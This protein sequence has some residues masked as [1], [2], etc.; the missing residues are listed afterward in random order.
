MPGFFSDLLRVLQG[1]HGRDMRFMCHQLL[2]ERGEASQTVLAQEI[3][4]TYKSMNSVQRHDF[5]D[6]LCREFSP[7]ESVI[8]Q[9]AADYERAPGAE[10]L[11][12]LSVAVEPPRQELIRR[13]NTAPRGTETLAPS[14][15]I[16]STLRLTER[17][18]AR[19]TLTSSIYSGHGST[20]GSCAWSGLAGKRQP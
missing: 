9:T 19:S 8:R 6:M 1:R 5:F 2:S 11:A 17:T 3:I 10:S 15:L 18:S 4:S 20:A 13:I 16:C 7:N 14:E 12:A